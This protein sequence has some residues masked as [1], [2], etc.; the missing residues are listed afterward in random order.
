MYIIKVLPF[1]CA[2]IIRVRTQLKALDIFFLLISPFS[3][4]IIDHFLIIFNFILGIFV[5]Y[6]KL[7]PIPK[8]PFRMHFHKFGLY[9]NNN[10]LVRIFFSVLM[11]TLLNKMADIRAYL[12][13]RNDY[14][15]PTISQPKQ[16]FYAS[17]I[18]SIQT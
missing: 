7:C 3:I 10:V 14:K 11:R 15:R 18:E 8:K 5:H 1:F 12:K 13:D 9:S 4:S 2:D 17:N 16:I 6:C